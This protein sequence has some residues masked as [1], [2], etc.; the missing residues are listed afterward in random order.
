MCVSRIH[1]TH[2]SLH[3]C[4]DSWWW[5]ECSECPLEKSGVPQYH[6]WTGS[7]CFLYWTPRSTEVVKLRQRGLRPVVEGLCGQFP[8]CTWHFWGQN[9]SSGLASTCAAWVCEGS[10]RL[11]GLKL[12]TT[13]ARTAEH[14]HSKMR[15]TVR[16]LSLYPVS[17]RSFQHT[18]SLGRLYLCDFGNAPC[19]GNAR[20]FARKMYT[21]ISWYTNWQNKWTDHV[22]LMDETWQ[23]LPPFATWHL[24]SANLGFFQVNARRPAVDSTPKL[25]RVHKGI[26]VGTI[27]MLPALDVFVCTANSW[28]AS[29]VRVG[30]RRCFIL[31]TYCET[32]Y[33]P[34]TWR[35]IFEV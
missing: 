35:R 29:A 28:W 16:A 9:A 3:P 24:K 19:L 13:Q 14:R 1:W 21:E 7:V 25:A 15:R 2:Q 6:L 4:L 18:N 23:K 5:D 20:G 22:S 27:W 10:N 26:Q 31:Q 32:V 11:G 17:L 34:S 30:F 12:Q 8:M 33:H